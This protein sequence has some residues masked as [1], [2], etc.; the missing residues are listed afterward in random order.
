CYILCKY[1]STDKCKIARIEKENNP[2]AAMLCQPNLLWTMRSF[3]PCFP[4]DL[5]C[6]FTDSHCHFVPS[7]KFDLR[8]D[9]SPSVSKVLLR[10]PHA[11][12][13]LVLFEKALGNHR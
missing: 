3:R 9:F 6:R 1:S 4:F 13:T 2:L 8:C 11:C 12:W 10:F 7:L 5:R